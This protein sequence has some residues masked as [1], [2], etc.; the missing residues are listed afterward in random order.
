[1]TQSEYKMLSNLIDKSYFFDDFKNKFANTKE[2]QRILLSLFE[3]KYVKLD[4]ATDYISI[5]LDGK[6]EYQRYKGNQ[7]DQF[8]TWFTR[9]FFA[10][11]ISGIIIGVASTLLVQVLLN[12][13]H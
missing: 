13:A 3:R 11:I 2:K 5:S 4:V 7:H 9:Q 1:M 12:L 6:I 10:G 8:K